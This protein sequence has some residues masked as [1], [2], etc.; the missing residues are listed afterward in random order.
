M[1]AQPVG[2]A[3][4]DLQQGAFGHAYLDRLGQLLHR[5]RSTGDAAPAQPGHAVV[6]EQVGVV[7]VPDLQRGG[8]VQVLVLE[9]GDEP[10]G[11]VGQADLGAERGQLLLALGPRQ[12][13]LGPV[14]VLA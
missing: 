5:L 4:H 3:R 9:V 1:P 2:G 11:G 12:Q 10:F 13:V 8:R 14:G 7:G 6:D